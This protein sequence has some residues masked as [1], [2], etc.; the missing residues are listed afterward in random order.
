MADTH[1]LHLDL[2]QQ[3]AHRYVTVPFEVAPGTDSIEIELDYDESVGVLDLGCEGPAGWRGWSGGARRRFVIGVDAAT[4]GYL[5][6]APEPGTWSVVL[7]LHA[8]PA[9]GLGVQVRVGV[10]AVGGVIDDPDAPAVAAPRGSSRGLPAPAGLTWFAGDFHAHTLHSDGS[11]GIGELAAAGVRAGLDFL[12]VTDHNTVSHHRLL[13]RAGARHDIVLL[14]GQEVTT[15]RGHANVFGD[16]GWIDFREPAATWQSE[17]ATRGGVFS[18][19]HP[20]TGDCSWQHPL[21]EPPQAIELGHVT[22]YSDLTS[23]APLAHHRLLGPD[24][25]VLGGSDFHRPDPGRHPGAPT[26]WV[27]ATGRTVPELLEAVA[28]GRTAVSYTNRRNGTEEVPDP[29][30]APVLL[31]VGED[32]V[33]DGADGLVLVDGAGRRRL[34]TGDRVRFPAAAFEGVAHLE[35]ADRRVWALSTTG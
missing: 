17:A 5:P 7:G 13:P 21:P 23:S 32:L 12:A 10:P 29:F 3:I 20:I 14:P 34:V 15:A 24:A 16:V 30:A 35:D 8:L 27:A 4:P 19:N 1:R 11:L 22:W 9:A 31:R 26:T 6:G 25:V 28:A 33:A 18:V 2:E